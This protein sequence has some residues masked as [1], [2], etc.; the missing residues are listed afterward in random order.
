MHRK[1]NG[2]HFKKIIILFWTLWWLAAFWTDGVGALAHL[3]WIH[4]SW[5]PDTNYPFLVQTLAMYHVPDWL[6]V[7]L[8][9]GIILWSLLASLLFCW[10]S[11]TLCGERVVW[12]RRA[13]CAFIVSMSLW[14]SFFL[15]DQMVMKYDLEENHMVQGGFELL[16]YL[17][18]FLLP[19]EPYTRTVT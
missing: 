12:M 1:L 6:P 17:V 4:A 3:G 5:A 7:L 10:T 15:A 2:I 19:E 9:I 8:F 13:H 18:V 14:F 16:C 11:L